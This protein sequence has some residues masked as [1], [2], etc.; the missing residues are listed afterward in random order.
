MQAIESRIVITSTFF[1]V[2]STDQYSR[3][4]T[5]LSTIRARH[6]IVGG[7]SA[8]V[9]SVGPQVEIGVAHPA[10]IDPHK[11]HLGTK[12]DMRAAVGSAVG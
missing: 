5:A 10:R 12:L 11:P 9:A 2:T 1:M 3:R 7:L 8:G 4:A 6:Q